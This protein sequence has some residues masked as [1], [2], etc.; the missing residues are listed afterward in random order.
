MD[1]GLDSVKVAVPRAQE[2]M[3]MQRAEPSTEAAGASTMQYCVKCAFLTTILPSDTPASILSMSD[4]SPSDDGLRDFMRDPDNPRT[5]AVA[6]RKAI[7]K[8]YMGRGPL[9]K[10][11][12]LHE[13]ASDTE[14]ALAGR[15][16][17]NLRAG[18]SQDVDQLGRHALEASLKRVAETL[19]ILR[20]LTPSSHRI[21]VTEFSSEAT[22]LKE[23][24][25]HSPHPYSL[26][27]K[28][29]ALSLYTLLAAFSRNSNGGQVIDAWVTSSLR[30][31]LEKVGCILYMQCVHFCVENVY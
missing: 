4:L 25:T 24:S 2:R 1:G 22:M 16:I 26:T 21:L 30:P 7:A 31:L 6:L 27:S 14:L 5:L 29:T 9:R 19:P 17:N 3:C 18:R 12:S 28:N 10:Y 15:H 23:A 13:H 11:R 20:S 8:V